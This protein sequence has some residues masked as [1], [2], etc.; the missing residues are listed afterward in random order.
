MWPLSSCD[1]KISIVSQCRILVAVQYLTHSCSRFFPTETCTC[2]TALWLG[3]YWR[4]LTQL[5]LLNDS[6]HT[7]LETHTN[8]KLTQT[9]ATQY[10]A[11]K[12]YT[13]GCCWCV[14]DGRAAAS[15]AAVSWRH[16]AQEMLP[17]RFQEIAKSE[18]HWHSNADIKSFICSK[19]KNIN[20]CTFRSNMP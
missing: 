10:T 17:S 16:H 11:Y 6:R 4:W 1:I 5:N 20:E 3:H 9:A 7:S 18:Q 19:L 2:W 15:S 13:A 12:Q 8:L 14:N